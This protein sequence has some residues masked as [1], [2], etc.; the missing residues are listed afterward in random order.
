[1]KIKKGYIFVILAAIIIA[2]YFYFS[3][4]KEPAYDFVIAQ[5]GDLI[6]KVNVIG[7]VEPAENVD[8]AFEKSGKVAEVKVEIG[9]RT[10][11]NQLLV[12][13]DSADLKAQFIQSQA[14]LESTQASLKQYQAALETEQANLD[15]LK[16]GAKPEDIQLSETKA[17]NAKKALTDA[18]TNLENVKN[19]ADID[20]T[21][22]Y[23]DVGDIL[24]DA[25]FYADDAV[26]NQIDNLF[27]NDNSDSP[28]LIIST[29]DSQA[30]IDIEPGRVTVRNALASFKSEI[31]GL[32]LNNSDQALLHG[33]N[34][35]NSI[36][37]FLNR[38]NDV[39]NSAT[40]LSQTTLS[41]YKSSI[42]TARTNIN[43]SISDIN[44]QRQSIV[45]QKII[46]ENNIAAAQAQVNTAKNNLNLAEDEL[47][48]KKSGATEEQIKAQESKV[49]Q[50]ELNIVS[51]QAKIKQAKAEI[52]N[53]QAQLDKTVLKSPISGV[54]V[55][56]EAKVGEI[57]SP[58]TPVVSI[59][60]QAD[61]EI[62]TNIPEADIA[63]IK[64]NNSADATLD[65]YGNDVVFKVQIVKISPAETMIEGVATYEVTLTFA[66][67]DERIK[68]GM[69]A[70]I[71]ILARQK[72]DVLIIPSRAVI[73]KDG[74]K[75]VNVLVKD[76]DGKDMVS[77]VK[78]ETGLKGS[79]GQIEIIKGL[80]IGEKA[81]LP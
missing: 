3:R 47:A 52:E 75:F 65:A 59:I 58:N 54:V 2:G 50:A 20:L 74:D 62:K 68:S 69:T 78:V 35:L 9:D 4:E 26:N 81:I 5:K 21:N 27:L 77:E 38:L 13:L 40:N 28:Q 61:F 76:K 22:L 44:A 12:V 63:K 10:E 32:T 45:S 11:K 64:L 42:N 23:D 53:I 16:K 55:K 14:S 80:D 70:D 33:E 34:Y 48:L 30:K 41:T 29:S 1:M 8:L 57:V 43:S 66:Q 17:A 79:D 31:N 19:K 56:Q 60:S 51:Q 36:R 71:N 25:Y 49:K 15:E 39:I 6:Q 72:K 73:N 7:R 67:K 24:N 37:Y 46:N 18:E